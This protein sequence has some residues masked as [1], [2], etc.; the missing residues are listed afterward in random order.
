MKALMVV[1]FGTLLAA[2]LAAL[3]VTSDAYARVKIP[4]GAYASVVGP[5]EADIRQQCAE[6]ARA[7]WGTNNQDMQTNRHF[8]L[9]GCLFDHGV[10]N[11]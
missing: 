1:A 11:P 5:S 6:V 8:T 7:R 3:T 10:R 9:S 4:P 2:P